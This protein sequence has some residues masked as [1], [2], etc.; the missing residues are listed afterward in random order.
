MSRNRSRG[1]STGA[2]LP[3][4]TMA[5]QKGMRTMTDEHNNTCTEDEDAY[6]VAMFESMD[7]WAAYDNALVHSGEWVGDR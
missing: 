1:L 7:I 6:L 4:L 3:V 5:G 2:T